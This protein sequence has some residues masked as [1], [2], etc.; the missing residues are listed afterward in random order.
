MATGDLKTRAAFKSSKATT[1]VCNTLLR[2]MYIMLND[3]SWRTG[4]HQILNN[5]HC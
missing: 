3:V 2:V 5:E 1:P 4:L